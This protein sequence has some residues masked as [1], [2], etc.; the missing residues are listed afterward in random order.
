MPLVLRR[1]RRSPRLV[2]L[3]KWKR[4]VRSSGV[5][6]LSMKFQMPY[7]ARR[8]TQKVVATSLDVKAVDRAIGLD[9]L[10]A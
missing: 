5:S 7:A 4:T 6:I 3:E 8:P 1:I 2:G 10:D 9:G